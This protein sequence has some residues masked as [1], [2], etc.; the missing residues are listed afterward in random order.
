MT[1]FSEISYPDSIPLI[2]YIFDRFSNHNV[3]PGERVPIFDPQLGIARYNHNIEHFL[4][5]KPDADTAVD[6]PT[7]AAVNNIGNLLAISFRANSSLGNISP[8]KKIQKLKGDLSKKVQNLHYVRDFIER[9]GPK[10]ETWNEQEITN[11][12][13]EMAKDGYKS[14]WKL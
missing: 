7:R 8:V 6:S 3:A 14:I 4:P 1:R 11:R 12:A 2:A 13:V 5:Q 9:Y 10:A